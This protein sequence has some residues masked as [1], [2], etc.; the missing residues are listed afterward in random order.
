MTDPRAST[1]LRHPLPRRPRPPDAGAG[2]SS[3]PNA[4]AGCGSRP[5]RSRRSGPVQR[6]ARVRGDVLVLTTADGPGQAVG[7]TSEAGCTC[8]CGCV[9]PCAPRGHRRGRGGRPRRRRRPASTPSA[10]G[11]SRRCSDER[12]RRCAPDRRSPKR[13]ASVSI[14]LSSSWRPPTRTSCR[15]SRSGSSRSSRPSR[16]PPPARTARIG[17]LR[18]GCPVTAGWLRSPC[19]IWPPW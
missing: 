16:R 10:I 11:C 14:S 5:R 15:P 3:S 4:A 19:S 7:S 1:A 12:A 2:P 18:R 9:D 8:R 17:G 6:R 13:T